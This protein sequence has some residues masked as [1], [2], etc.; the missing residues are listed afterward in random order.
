MIVLA[1]TCSRPGRRA[2]RNGAPPDPLNDQ[3]VGSLGERRFDAG[4]RRRAPRDGALPDPF[5]NQLV[6]SLG[7]RRLDAGGRRRAPRA[8]SRSECGERVFRAGPSGRNG[9]RWLVPSRS[10]SAGVC[11]PFVRWFGG[12]RARRA[13][14]TASRTAHYAEGD[15]VRGGTGT[16]ARTATTV[17][18]IIYKIMTFCQGRFRATRFAR[19]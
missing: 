15:T 14:A 2:S 13:P 1:T 5:N 9:R 17:Q 8:G 11:V 6:G 16:R 10:V 4:G 7:E 3:L 19:W 18:E 12:R